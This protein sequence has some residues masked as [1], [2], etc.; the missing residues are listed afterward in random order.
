MSFNKFFIFCCYF[1]MLL[2]FSSCNDGGELVQTWSY[3]ESLLNQME[4]EW[5]NQNLLNY[6]KILLTYY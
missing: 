4:S 1:F 2:S 3:D 5:N 6:I